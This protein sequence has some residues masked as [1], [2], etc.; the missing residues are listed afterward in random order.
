L[1]FAYPDNV[2]FECNGCGLC[3]GD[4]DRKTRRILL[5]ESEAQTI[6]NTTGQPITAFAER[7]A[8]KEPYVY[9]MKK[10][11]GGRCFFLKDNICTV[12]LLRPL[13][14][15]FYPFQLSFSED[16]GNYIFD[17]TVECPTIGKG[18]TLT[19]KEFEDLFRLAQEKL[20]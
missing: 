16:K 9:D 8:G 20:P 19:R 17:F 10:P 4:T 13:I 18:K 1:D 5:L 15:H 11:S 14:C 12:Y 7:I 6:A 2:C 3:C